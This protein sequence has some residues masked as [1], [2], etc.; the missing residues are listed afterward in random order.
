[1]AG[2]TEY[3][4][5]IAFCGDEEQKEYLYA[6]YSS[7]EG[8]G[9]Q[10]HNPIGLNIFIPNETLFEA[11]T[12]ERREELAQSHRIKLGIKCRIVNT[13]NEIVPFSIISKPEIDVT[14]FRMACHQMIFTGLGRDE[15]Y[16]PLDLR[17][18]TECRLTRGELFLQLVTR[19]LSTNFSVEFVDEL[20][21]L[22]ESRFSGI[23]TTIPSS[24]RIDYIEPFTITHDV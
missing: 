18:F 22:E 6:K 17:S 19:D 8:R 13:L 9:W 10:R 15:L 3:R 12:N 21:I 23:T 14:Y 7:Y 1:M 20:H 2:S 4:L 24:R 16:V 11:G 5:Q